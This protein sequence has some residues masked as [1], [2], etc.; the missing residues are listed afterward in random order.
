MGV[1]MPLKAKTY[2]GILK[3]S[4]DK[5]YKG[6]SATFNLKLVKTDMVLLKKNKSIKIG[7]YTVKLSSKQYKSLVKSFNKGKY[8]SIKIVTNYKYKVKV[9]YT[10][11]VKH[12]KTTKAVKTLYAGSYLPMIN[13]MEDNGWTL[14]S[15][16]TYTKPSKQVWYRIKCIHLCSM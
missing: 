3:F 12:Y 13:R 1:K 8:K 11:T 7:K 2:K 16:Y 4:G 15:E 14:V 9:P 10:K 5:N 6:C